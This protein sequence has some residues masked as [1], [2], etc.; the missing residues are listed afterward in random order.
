LRTLG[1]ADGFCALGFA[2]I[3][4]DDEAAA[5]ALEKAL[6]SGGGRFL[7][8]AMASLIGEFLP[9]LKKRAKPTGGRKKAHA[10]EGQL[11]LF[12]ETDG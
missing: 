10:D 3:G 12:G 1:E 2:L 11:E 8:G 6:A 7:D 4:K 5:A 9:A